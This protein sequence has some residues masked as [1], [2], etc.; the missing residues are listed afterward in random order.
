MKTVK[1]IQLV[2]QES[3]QEQRTSVPGCNPS[4]ISTDLQGLGTTG[5][6]EPITF[7]P[8]LLTCE[9]LDDRSWRGQGLQPGPGMGEGYIDAD[10]R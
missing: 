5:L 3:N 4:Q 9:G 6:A 1:K 2:E 7:K 10:M 8:T